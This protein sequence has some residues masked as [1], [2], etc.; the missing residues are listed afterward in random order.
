MDE[1]YRPWGFYDILAD[2]ENHKVKR[3]TVYPHQRLSL[4]QHEKR[5]EHWFVIEGQGQVTLLDH[6][7]I[8]VT[9]G[10]SI[11]IP[12]RCAHRIENTGTSNLVFVEIQ[13]GSYF[14]E[15]DI[16]RLEDDYGRK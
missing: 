11:D 7:H 6:R 3:I 12:A 14:G 10:S 9:T 1:R 5:S 2:S 15:D 16:E 4:Q 13:T 8:E